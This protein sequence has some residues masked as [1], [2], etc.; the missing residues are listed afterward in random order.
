VRHDE[1]RWHGA[2]ITSMKQEIKLE[3]DERFAEGEARLRLRF[4]LAEISRLDGDMTPRGLLRRFVFVVTALVHHQ[5]R[6]GLTASQV[7]QLVTLAQAT[8]AAA[9][10]RPRSSRLSHLHAELHMIT[11]QIHR[12]EGRQWTAAWEQ[13][14]GVYLARGG[15]EEEPGFE[16]LGLANRALRLGHLRLAAAR[17]E[18]AERLGLAESNVAKARLGLIK[19]HRLAGHADKLRP[20]VAGARTEPWLAGQARLE[21]D[22][23]RLCAEV[24]ASGECRPLRRALARGRPHFLGTY[25]VEGYLWIAAS[26][27]L[28]GWAGLPSIRYLARDAAVRPQRQG[29]FYKFALQIERCYLHEAP[30]PIRIRQLGALLAQVTRLVSIDK[31][32]LAWAA[33]ARWLARSKSYALAALALHE[34]EALSLRVTSG[35]N[36][37]A[38]GLCADLLAK[39]WYVGRDDVEDAAATLEAA[40]LPRSA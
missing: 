29:L 12:R 40:P 13:Y 23:E 19:T 10:V 14:Y 26:S 32:L 31:E 24:Q 33:S 15:R 27:R 21:L 39:D 37:D 17:F 36:A 22:W 28:D 34:Y 9:G 6:G 4:V 38:L 5:R 11:S 18:Q 30:L 1:S 7:R 20:L 25:L 3:L 16:T 2:L 8:L 35:A